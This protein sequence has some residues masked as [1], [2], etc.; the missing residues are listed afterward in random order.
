MSEN[1]QLYKLF[2]NGFLHPFRGPAISSLL[3]KQNCVHI[4]PSLGVMIKDIWED[5][6]S[7]FLL[8]HRKCLKLRVKIEK[9]NHWWIRNKDKTYSP[10]IFPSSYASFQIWPW[11]CFNA[12]VFRSELICQRTFFTAASMIVFLLNTKK[13]FF[14]NFLNEG[15]EIKIIKKL[16]QN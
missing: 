6:P 10:L 8:P 16:I 11:S 2:P 12:V 13:N 15:E 9:F 14:F 1:N 5:E 3:F 7:L 4:R